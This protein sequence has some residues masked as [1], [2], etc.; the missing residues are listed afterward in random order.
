MITIAWNISLARDRIQLT[1]SLPVGVEHAVVNIPAP[2]HANGTQAASQEC[3]VLESGTVLWKRNAVGSNLWP[4]G[5][6]SVRVSNATTHASSSV[7]TVQVAVVGNGHFEFEAS[8]L[9]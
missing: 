1:V 5:V 2:F 9:S 8:V 7:G 4:E 6:S 3:T